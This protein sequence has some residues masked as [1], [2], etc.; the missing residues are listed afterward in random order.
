VT[1]LSGTNTNNGTISATAGTLLFSGASALSADTSLLSAS[2]ATL[3]LADG[4]TRNSTMTG[5]LTLNASNFVFDLNGSSS[6]L[7]AVTGAATLL[8]TNTVKLNLSGGAIASSWT[9]MTAA[10]GLNGT[11][12][13]DN[14]SFNAGGYAFSLTA[15]GTTLTLSSVLS[16][17]NYYWKGSTSGNWTTANNWTSDSAGNN[18]SASIP[19]SASDLYF[20]AD[21]ASNL[22][23]TLG[24][25]FTINTLSISDANGV[26]INAG[27]TITASATSSTAYNITATSGTTTINAALAGTGAGLTKNGNGTLI[28]GGSNT[29]AGG[30]QLLGGTL[31][32]TSSA[33]LGNASNS[34]TINPGAGTTATLQSGADN[35][36][37]A[38][39]QS[40][41]LSSGT[42]AFDTQSYNLSL[43]GAIS[44]TGVLQKMGSGTLT[45][46][47]NNTYSGLTT[48]SAGTF[49][50]TGSV[51]ILN[52]GTVSLADSAGVTFL[53]SASEQIGSLQGGGLSGG[54]ASIAAGQMLTIS[55]AGT[56]QT[57]NGTF[58]GAGGLSK[59][60]SG[61]II[62]T[63]SNSSLGGMVYIS[64]GVLS[65]TGIGNA[66]QNSA[67]GANATI[68][69]G[70]ENTVGTLVWNGAADETT[71]K[72]LEIRSTT[73]G[74]STS[75]ATITSNASGRTLAFT[76]NLSVIGTGNKT[77]TLNGAGNTIFSGNIVNG[78]NATV[79]LTK[80]G[81]G[82]LT[83]SGS[84]SYTGN[85]L[86]TAGTLQI[87]NGGTTGS[88][89]TSSAITNNGTLIFNRSNAIVQGTD[90]T[91]TA[92]SGSGSL[93]Q[94]GSGSLTLSSANTYSGG[95][96]LSAGT[97]N[98]N[99]ATAISS[100]SLVLAGGTVDNTSGSAITLSNNNSQNWNGDFTFA[101]SNAMNT[102]NGSVA[103]NASRQ[104]TISNSTFTV[105]G[106]ISGNSFGL[107]KDGNGTLLLT[108]N[109]T[110]S[111]ATVI[112]AGTLQ[113]G[114][115]G[116][117]GGLST[118]SA[119]T[120]NGTLVFNRSNAI[121]QGTNFSSAA[122]SGTGSLTLNLGTL[123]LNGSNT[124]S[125]G[126]T[127]TN[128]TIYLNSAS[129]IGTGALTINGGTVGSTAGS[130]VTLSTNNTQY[131]NADFSFSNTNGLNMGTGN[132]ILSGNRTVTTASGTTTIA[133]NISGSG[134][135]LNKWGNSGTLILTGSNSYTGTTTVSQGTL[136]IS[137]GSAIS[138]TGT[139]NVSGAEDTFI[140]NGSETI[141]SLQGAG[142]TTIASGQTLTVAETGN[143]TYSGLIL[144]S[145]GLTKTGSGNMTLSGANSY[146]GAT[147]VTAGTLK[148][149]AAD[150][151]SDSSN[152]LVN[153]GSFNI[154]GFNET[155]GSVTLTSGTLAGTGTL[156]SSSGY[157]VQSGTIS[158]NLGGA[159]G[160]TKS[161][162]GSVFLTG[163]NSYSGSTVISAGTLS[164]SALGAVAST[165]GITM[166]N[167]SN[168]TYTGSAGNLTKSIAV[169]SGTGTI[170]NAGS[171]LLTLSG[172]L[173]KNG[174]TLVLK[175][176]SNGITVSGSIGGA[177]PN[178]D[179]LIDG[180]FTTLAN[181]N[182]YNGPTYLQNGASL[183]AS[184]ADALPTANGRS[185]VIMDATGTGS[186][187]L[188]L[189]AS[190]S[191][192][193]LTGAASSSVTLGS[194]TLT[195]GTSTGSTTY[196]GGISGTGALVKDGASTQ[197]LTGTNTY[198]GGTTISAGTL[199]IDGAGQ[200]GS[201]SYSGNISNAGTLNYASSAN[202]TLSGIISGTG[203][204]TKDGASTLTLT[205]A[206]TYNG[207]TTITS[208][209]LRAGAADALGDT[210]EVMVNSGGSL[211]I[212]ASEAIDDAAA[213]ELA[214][215]TMKFEGNV[216]ETLGVFS[217][218]AN[219]SIDMGMGSV[220][221][222]FAN[223][224]AL[225][226]TYDLKILNYT[227]YTDHLYF[228]SD[229]HA[230]LQNSLSHIRFYS[231]TDE[232][233]F[234]GNSFI[235]S[236][237]P[238]HVRPVPEPET[239][240]TA[241]LLL[242]G[243]GIFAYR[244]RQSATS[245]VI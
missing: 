18:L 10:S 211:L 33:S 94:S 155:V 77:F 231:G 112:N 7:L 111:G 175:G 142:N 15:N 8:G 189:G 143:Q 204:L 169:T 133:G 40:I 21:G 93:V 109:N 116:T 31:Q 98:I 23:T 49:A 42:A 212:A 27:N 121:V 199:T 24:Q 85:T 132:I 120:N 28:L 56:T 232:S 83:L 213:V 14:A 66:T 152:L 13:L 171:G 185:A 193:S 48:I 209:T 65:V 69:F 20:S 137:G 219:S 57:Y 191:I 101:G 37:L 129:A 126:T 106:V 2:G 228:A 170:E 187:T 91:S 208:G 71:N 92:I 245:E 50:V 47:G 205:H 159:V 136:A 210:R 41:A 240:A 141:G 167:G 122:I 89:E 100:G 135:S 221:L 73:A 35:I 238:Y 196:A 140:V 176:G 180:G 34:L 192:A 201:G 60:G 76:S 217:L 6:D 216:T 36:T 225:I 125:G 86:I 103:M 202:Q 9:L 153:G 206:N 218:S 67:L 53:V 3:S 138:D 235:E 25:D 215:G 81:A 4:T 147:T 110:Y 118:S 148:L 38:G 19:S 55:E 22:S 75:G 124:Y 104:I 32:I 99:N 30:T 203:A 233:S 183:T 236:L 84:N 223:L 184:I 68:Q 198:T 157:D 87:G 207:T 165:S 230:D 96:T 173:T 224:A 194:N 149:A 17:S 220:W 151:I 131:W 243:L 162:L 239:Y 234:I 108:S 128:G 134:F 44:G 145:G 197:I 119:I 58:S 64:N 174:T 146:T 78:A 72:I 160:L 182:T 195:M 242:L 59:S 222:Q 181:A 186:S 241:A 1:T 178:S 179:L 63:N 29:Y 61:T 226:V 229:S 46:S 12:S 123:T 144:G 139:V 70:D 45:L 107:T 158:V 114:A 5:T 190:Q 154:A 54:T 166:D 177:N 26:V 115:G 117:S 164:I 79:S 82:T 130:L 163:N 188:T 16:S 90:F 88:L 80:S 237:N 95:T 227:L 214:G 113:I 102:G 74:N 39:T 51:A 52:T 43:A 161:T 105:G 244:R 127:L 97:L 172:A 156:T 200:L 62:L 168:L 11:W 150:R